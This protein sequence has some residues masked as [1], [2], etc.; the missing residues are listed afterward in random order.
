VLNNLPYFRAGGIM[1]DDN[2]LETSRSFWLHC[3]VS[4]C[5]LRHF[6]YHPWVWKHNL[7]PSPRLGLQAAGF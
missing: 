7:F 4:S 2:L 1:D 6:L 3:A 5:S